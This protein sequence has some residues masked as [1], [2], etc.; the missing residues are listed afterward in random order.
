MIILRGKTSS[1]KTLEII[2]RFCKDNQSATL[3]TD[4]ESLGDIFYKMKFLEEQEELIINTEVYKNI[5]SGQ[6]TN[7][8]ADYYNLI[9]NN[10][11]TKS[12]YLDLNCLSSEVRP[13]IIK[14]C[15]DLE[16]EYGINF[17]MTQL[18]AGGV[19]SK[20]NEKIEYKKAFQVIK[21]SKEDLF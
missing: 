9:N 14:Y 8:D 16:S 6:F 21:F 19:I 18:V 7:C 11:N 10:S 15:L 13:N 4:D 20:R 1:G 3:I 12:I 17:T 2:R 5:I